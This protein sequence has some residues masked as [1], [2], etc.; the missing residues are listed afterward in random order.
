[1]T[2]EFLTIEQKTQY[3]QFSDDPDEI[4]LT[5]YFHLDETDLSFILNRRGDQNKLGFALQLTSVRFLGTFLSDVKFVP[6]NVQIFVA[7]QLSIQD[8][9]VLA[10]YTQRDTTKREHTA[11]IRKHYGY[12]EFSDPP[13]AF[14]LSRLLYTRAWI[15]NERP[16]LM[17]DFATAWLIQNKILLPGISTLSRLISEIRE[18]AFNRLWKKL[19]SLPT[20]EQ[21][22]KLETLLQIPEGMRISRFDSYR[23]GP[24]TISSPAFN[25]TVERYLELQAFGLQELDF[26]HI[27]PVRMKTLARH[28]SI[29]SMHKIAR[30]SDDKRI[31]ILLAFVKSYEIIALDDALDILDML[32]TGIAGNAKKL[33]QKKRLRTLKDLDKSALVLA[34]VC[35]LILNEETKDD[36][37]RE[38]IF[39]QMS[40]V[41]LMESIA[42]VKNLARSPDNKYEGE[43]IE[44]Y[45][46]VRRFL[47]RLLNDIKFMA[48]PAGKI[49][50]ASD[51]ERKSL[52]ANSEQFM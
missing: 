38:T 23:K 50:L 48:A 39:T 21:K 6:N 9:S 42:T 40:K 44:Q 4:H 34:K 3:G 13:W 8:V 36:Q 49:T 47:P 32:I 45:G 29:I 26:S 24:V 30:M 11:L 16:S 41:Q 17:F 46:K 1:M 15:S 20:K 2:V 7:G 35:A 52:K 51:I 31:A 12:R 10:D 28:A 14:R 27:P 22:E 18:R 43:M 33:G 25:A 37:I 19:S 5:R